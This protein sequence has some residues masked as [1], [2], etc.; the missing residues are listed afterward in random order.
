MVCLPW[1]ILVG[2]GYI[3]LFDFTPAAETKI[4]EITEAKNL[5]MS[6]LNAL[7]RESNIPARLK[8]NRTR[9][10]RATVFPEMSQN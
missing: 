1:N 3:L 5:D 2:A 10:Y 4:A 8:Y 9:V 7:L 6:L